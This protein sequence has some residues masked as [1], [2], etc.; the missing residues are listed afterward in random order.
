VKHTFLPGAVRVVSASLTAASFLVLSAA[1]GPTVV[2]PA[3]AQSHAH[4]QGHQ[5]GPNGGDMK[6]IA[7]V[8]AEIL[9]AGR[10]ITINVF[11]DADKPAS[12]KGF[13]GSA[14]V[15][16]GKTKETVTLAPSGEAALQGE[17]KGAI[18]AGA[19]ITILLKTEAGK[20]GQV[21]FSPHDH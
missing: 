17:A 5:K 19:T 3:L 1:V 16:D 15:S 21:R 2:A 6:D 9:V 11:D 10:T 18:A 7:G 14:L 8:H 4:G 13:T 12:T 20:T